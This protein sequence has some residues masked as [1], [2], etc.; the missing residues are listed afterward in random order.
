MRNP[1]QN[2]G[3]YRYKE[4][5]WRKMKFYPRC[6]SFLNLEFDLPDEGDGSIDIHVRCRGSKKHRGE[7]QYSNVTSTSTFSFEW[8]NR[9]DR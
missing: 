6:T 4:D 9:R 8:E 5:E 2:V 1:C 7:H 3:A